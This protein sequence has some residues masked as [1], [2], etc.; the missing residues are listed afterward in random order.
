MQLNTMGTYSEHVTLGVDHD[1]AK[2]SDK[3]ARYVMREL[4]IR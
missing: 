1:P 2:L 4:L 3:D